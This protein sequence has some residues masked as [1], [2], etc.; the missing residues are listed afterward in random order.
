MKAFAINE[1]GNESYTHVV[2][3]DTRT[4]AIRYAMENCGGDFADVAYTDMR[5]HMEPKLDAFE[6]GRREM[7]WNNME[8]RVAMVREAGFTC[9]REIGIKLERCESQCAA[10]EWC[11]RYLHLKEIWDK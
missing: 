3:A 2:F 1:K 5:A 8:D 6:N 7:D 4:E 9:G 10:Y 11:S